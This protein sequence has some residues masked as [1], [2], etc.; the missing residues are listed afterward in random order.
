[1][2]CA[3]V[4]RQRVGGGGV[5]GEVGPAILERDACA[6]HYI[7]AAE[8]TIV[9]LDE[10]DGVAL[11]IRRAHVDGVAGNGAWDSRGTRAL[12]VDVCPAL[13][14]KCG[15]EQFAWVDAHMREIGE[16]TVTVGERQLFCLDRG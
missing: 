7:T 9:A 8:A 1:M 5:Q 4:G 11:F 12:W 2:Q 3:L 10:R 13:V 14:Q 15:R 6:V 16:V